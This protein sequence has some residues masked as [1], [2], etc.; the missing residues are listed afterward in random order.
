MACIEINMKTIEDKLDLIF[1]NYSSRQ[2]SHFIEDFELAVFSVICIE[3]KN[4]LLKKYTSIIDYEIDLEFDY[5]DIRYYIS[6][7]YPVTD[8]KSKILCSVLS[9]MS[10]INDESIILKSHDVK[11]L[12]NKTILEFNIASCFAKKYDNILSLVVESLKSAAK[13]LDAF[14]LLKIKELESTTIINLNRK[15]KQYFDRE[16]KPKLFEKLSIGMIHKNKGVYSF[17]TESV[18][19][20]IKSISNTGNQ[21]IDPYTTAFTMATTYLDYDKMFSKKA[22]E[23]E[24]CLDF[25]IPE[26]EYTSSDSQYSKAEITFYEGVDNYSIFPLF[27]SRNY[28]ISVGFPR[29]YKRMMVAILEK[30]NVEI[31]EFLDSSMES[32]ARIFNQFK[33]K[34]DLEKVIGDGLYY[35]T[36]IF[37]ALYDQSS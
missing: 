6:M 18:E 32:F 33:S 7:D 15:L 13:W 10:F 14:M 36:R 1:V 22:L 35:L 19:S 4:L 25:S 8:V 9:K 2:L 29:K 37:K 30:Y 28:M 3:I 24:D 27:K 12:G 17:T 16:N 23:S 26:A 11:W 20:I 31:D 21:L 5:K 34:L